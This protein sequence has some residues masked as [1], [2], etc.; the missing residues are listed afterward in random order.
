MS[1]VLELW[2][3]VR[4]RGCFVGCSA[5][6]GR[7]DST[8]VCF[9]CLQI[10]S[11]IRLV[12]KKDWIVIRAIIE[13]IATDSGSIRVYKRVNLASSQWVLAQKDLIVVNLPAVGC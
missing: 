9:D 5:A 10:G 2:A 11:I 13:L 8:Q 12:E 6:V 1:S 7:T 3:S 4:K